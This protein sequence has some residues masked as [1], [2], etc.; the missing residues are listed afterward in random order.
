MHPGLATP[1]Q[2]LSGPPDSP[3][4]AAGG[5]AAN[6]PLAH[7]QILRRNGAAGCMR[8]PRMGLL[9]KIEADASSTA[10]LRAFGPGGLWT[11]MLVGGALSVNWTLN[12]VSMRH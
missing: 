1:L 8:C 11:T 10:R 3:Q 7:Y 5:A 6:N 4:P 2:P 9:L 12:M